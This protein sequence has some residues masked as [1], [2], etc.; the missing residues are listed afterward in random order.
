[1]GHLTTIGYSTLI[2]KYV[3]G[4]TRSRS[5]GKIQDQTLWSTQTQVIEFGAMFVVF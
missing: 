1:M 4:R 2:V 5:L 3:Q